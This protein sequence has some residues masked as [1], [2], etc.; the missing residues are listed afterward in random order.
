MPNYQQYKT[1]KKLVT[2]ARFPVIVLDENIDLDA[3]GASLAISSLMND[4]KKPHFITCSNAIPVA[5]SQILDV[6]KI[7]VIKSLAE[8]S[9]LPDIVLMLDIGNLNQLGDLYTNS[10]ELFLST[11]I[12]HIDHHVES[13]ISSHL[14]IIDATAAATCEQI[15]LLFQDFKFFPPQHIATY[16]LAGIASD[17]RSYSTPNVTPRTLKTASWLIEQGAD[18]VTAS[19]LAKRLSFLQLKLWGTSLINI[20]KICDGQVGL[21]T[22]TREMMEEAGVENKSTSGLINLIDDVL[23]LKASVLLKEI[24]TGEVR[25]SF[26]SPKKI[27]VVKIAKK[28]GGGGHTYAAA[29]NLGRIGIDKAKEIITAEFSQLIREQQD[30]SI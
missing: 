25:A 4:W 13:S 5:Y 22:V 15:A 2:K 18:V 20:E 26:R 10:Q 14:G 1:L 28:F 19:R 16:L 7:S 8:L 17:T 6:A 30:E 21:V 9:T 12:V 29:C 24:P 23:E 11:K 27:R 3:L